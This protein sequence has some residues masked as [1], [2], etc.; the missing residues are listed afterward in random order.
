MQN[1][2]D[3]KYTNKYIHTTQLY[4]QLPAKVYV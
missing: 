1:N 3:W 2:N 4:K